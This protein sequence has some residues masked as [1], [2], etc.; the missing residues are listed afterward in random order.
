MHTYRINNFIL[1]NRCAY[2]MRFVVPNWGDIRNICTFVFKC[3][4]IIY[5]YIHHWV[6][7]F[8]YLD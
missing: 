6:P 5:D 7:G 8:G 3:V 1:T 4:N 2:F